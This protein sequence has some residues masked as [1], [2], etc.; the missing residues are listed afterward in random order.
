MKQE[1]IDCFHAHKSRYGRIRIQKELEE[2]GLTLSQ[3]FISETLRDNGLRARSKAP[4]RPKTTITS[5]TNIADNT[6][7]STCT[8]RPN[9]VTVTD[10]T[11]IKTKEGWLY[12]AAIMDLH[13][14][15]IKGYHVGESLETSLVLQAF[16]KALSNYPELAGSLH[17][18]DRGCQYTSKAYKEALEANQIKLSMSAQGYCYDNAHMESFWASLKRE[19]GDEPIDE[20][21]TKEDAKQAIFEYIYG[22]YNTV[23][24]HSALN[25][26]S[27]LETENQLILP[28]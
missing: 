14:R 10:I 5:K 1:I 20:F 18:T 13:T 6:L 16:H 8:H 21:E 7:A 27:P 24:K 2:E 26:K 17:H 9:Q 4:Y 25:Y 3:P 23:R 15:V 22:Y 12:L 19:I 11:Y 28:S